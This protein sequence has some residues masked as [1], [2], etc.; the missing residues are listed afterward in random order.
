METETHFEAVTPPS[1]IAPTGTVV[2]Y[3]SDKSRSVSLPTYTRAEFPVWARP[4][5]AEGPTFYVDH[6]D[7]LYSVA[8][9]LVRGVT[10]FI[11]GQPGT[12]KTAAVEH[13]ASIL[14]V[15][16]VRI[17]LTEG[18]EVSRLTGKVNLRGGQTGWQ[19]GRVTR[20]MTLPS[21][22]CL[23]EYNAATGEVQFDLR[24]VFDGSAFLALDDDNGRLVTR[25]P[26]CFFVLTGNP[27]WDATNT[28][29]M[30]MAAADSD[31]L[32]HSVVGWPVPEVEFD[33]G[34]NAVKDH[35]ISPEMVA[36][37]VTM[38]G[39]L[40]KLRDDGDIEVNVGIR[41]LLNFLSAVQYHSPGQALR[42]VYSYAEPDEVDRLMILLEGYSW[43]QAGPAPSSLTAK[44]ARARREVDPTYVEPTPEPEPEPVGL[45]VTDNPDQ[46]VEDL[47]NSLLAD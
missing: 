22:I 9:D 19:D 27:H 16:F 14:S 24:A 37:A 5:I 17:Q 10:P 6:D 47:L 38:W 7:A 4:L 3:S 26:G 15:P 30:P 13:L 28:G 32:S 11:W 12:G 33:V 31:R 23:D 39:D 44:V 36:N 18:S 21:V 41:S 34:W 35:G 20:Y 40:R 42:K 8:V 25:H 29:L 45:P 2:I 1:T 43:D 46:A